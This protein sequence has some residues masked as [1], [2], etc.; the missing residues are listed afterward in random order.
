LVKLLDEGFA[1]ATLASLLMSFVLIDTLSWTMHPSFTLYKTSQ[2][3][4]SGVASSVGA[5]GDNRQALCYTLDT[6]FF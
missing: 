2:I 1:K 3:S 6:T 5:T 4:S